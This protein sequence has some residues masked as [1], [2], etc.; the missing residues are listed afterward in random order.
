MHTR[1]PTAEQERDACTV[2]FHQDVETDAGDVPAGPQQRRAKS[3]FQLLDEKD[4][5]TIVRHSLA[6]TA[7]ENMHLCVLIVRVDDLAEYHEAYGQGAGTTLMDRIGQRL[8]GHLREADTVCKIR[9]DEFG[10]VSVLKR[11]SDIGILAEK[12]TGC[13]ATPLE[14]DGKHAMPK[15]SVGATLSRRR[16]NDEHDMIDRAKNAMGVARADGGNRWEVHSRAI[17]IK[18][19]RKLA[20]IN[21]LNEGL[22]SRRFS[23][24]YQP[25]VD[26]GH[27]GLVGSEALLRWRDESGRMVPPSKFIPTAEESGLIGQLGAWI[28]DEVCRQQRDWMDRGLAVQPVSVNVSP[29]QFETPGFGR[30]IRDAVAQWGISPELIEIEITES[31]LVRDSAAVHDELAELRRH[32][33]RIALDDFGTGYS[34]L[35]YLPTLPI[36]VLKIDRS[37]VSGIDTRPVNSEIVR[38]IIDLSHSLKMQVVAEGVESDR[39]RSFLLQNGCDVGQGFLFSK[40]IEGARFER[41]LAA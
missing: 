25:K 14:L 9:R 33:F 4:F 19:R 34:C 39:H 27:A 36:D 32:G 23:V 41:L 12:L 8:I 20:L 5:T 37:F 30:S 29:Q 40:P 3:D 1:E 6:I 13:L 11:R 10:V 28:L 17:S 35:G 31:S 7:R 18:A 15:F 38:M 21:A 26:L 16:Q 22:A 2:A 24:F